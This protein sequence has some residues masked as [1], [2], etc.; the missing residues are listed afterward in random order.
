M[1]K[2]PIWALVPGQK[3]ARAIFSSD[4]RLLLNAGVVLTARLISRL[5]MLGIPALYISDGL[6]PDLE[7]PDV[8]SEETRRDAVIAVRRLL[9]DVKG[10]HKRPIVNRVLI[11]TEEMFSTVNEIIDQLLARHDLVVNL[12]DMRMLDDYTFGHCVN[13]CVLSLLTGI[14]MGYERSRLLQLG[15]GAMLHD[16]GKTR[17]PQ[18]ILNK[19]EPLT[20]DEFEIIKKHTVYGFEIL[21]KFSGISLPVATVALQHH[22]RWQGQGYPQGLRGALIHEYAAITSVADAFD[23]MTADRVYRKA[24]PAHEAYEM[25]AG[26]GDYLFDFHIVEAFLQNIA[27]YPLGTVVELTTGQIGVVVDTPRGHSVRPTIRLLYDR[28]GHAVTDSV[29]IALVDYPNLAICRVLDEDGLQ[30]LCIGRKQ[31]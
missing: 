15:M 21:R 2:V 13:V 3:V 11:R 24:Y 6:L 5:R 8:I 4:G 9:E 16:I 25:V 7:I 23:A 20:P 17:V 1:R 22:E 28:E 18:E 29:E 27:A 14:T 12:V 26:S 31:G 30:H 19:P 10:C